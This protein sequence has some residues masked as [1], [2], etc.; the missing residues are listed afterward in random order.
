VPI[1]KLRLNNPLSL[2]ERVRVREKDYKIV[3]SQFPYPHPCLLP[4]GEGVKT[5]VSG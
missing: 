1:Q 3:L 5:P 2:R 4:E